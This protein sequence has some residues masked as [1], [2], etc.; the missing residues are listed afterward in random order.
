MTIHI[1][2]PITLI[3]LLAGTAV[4]LAWS[5]APGAGG[6]GTAPA[7]A[8]RIAVANVL[9]ILYGMQE[10]K[11]LTEALRT[12]NKD[13]EAKAKEKGAALEQM[14]EGIRQVKPDSP[15][16]NDKLKDL[17]NAMADLESWEKVARIE[18]ERDQKMMMKNL[19]V[20]IKG[21][22]GD[23]AKEEGYDVVL[24]SQS[25]DFPDLEHMNM[26]QL[27][28]FIKQQSVLYAAKGLD[29]SDAVL[30]RLDANYAKEKGAK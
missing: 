29:I 14:R 13:L 11:E 3:G 26:D 10:T 25:D 19:F 9:R 16:Y 22:I 8:P 12:K 2:R 15:Q 21:A 20:K 6:P 30:T 27:G 28:G 4:L 5:F 17:D 23:I 1:T 24:A 18:A 7:G